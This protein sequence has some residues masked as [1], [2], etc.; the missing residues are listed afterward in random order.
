MKKNGAIISFIENPSQNTEP[1]TDL[2]TMIIISTRLKRN[3]RR[4]ETDNNHASQKCHSKTQHFLSVRSSS[5]FIHLKWTQSTAISK[6]GLLAAMDKNTN[7]ELLILHISVA[8]GPR[9]LCLSNYPC[10]S[11][12]KSSLSTRTCSYRVNSNNN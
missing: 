4:Q 10:S 1:S 6:Q 5:R 12:R 3:Q 7:T 11:L 8:N 9:I 2:I